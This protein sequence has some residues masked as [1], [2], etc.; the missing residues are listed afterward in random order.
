MEGEW[1]RRAPEEEAPASR[2]SS[3]DAAR[4]RRA[5]CVSK[6][7]DLKAKLQ[8]AKA[9]LAPLQSQ[10]N[11]N[12]KTEV[13]GQ[14]RALHAELVAAKIYNEGEAATSR[15]AL[16]SRNCADKNARELAVENDHL[17]AK[18][19]SLASSYATLM[20]KHASGEKKAQ[21]ERRHSAQ[22]ERQLRAS[23]TR[24]ESA[25]DT[26][27]QEALLLKEEAE[28]LVGEALEDMQ[29][30]EDRALEAKTRVREAERVAGEALTESKAAAEDAAAARY[31]LTDAG[32]VSSI[33]TAKLHRAEAKA[34]EKQATVL[35]QQAELMRGPRERTVDEWAA[36]NKESKWKAEQRERAYL[37][38]F[39]KS[40]PFRTKDIAATL[41]ELSTPHPTPP[42]PP[43]ADERQY[44]RASS[45]RV[46]GVL[47]R[48][49]QAA[50]PLQPAHRASPCPPPLPPLQPDLVEPLFK[51]EPFFT[52]YFNRVDAL[53]Q[54]L[55]K[56]EFGEVFGLF[57]HYE[58]KLT[59]NKILRLTQAASKKYDKSLDRYCTKV[60]LYNPYRKGE[61]V[62]VP[63]LAP[64]INKMDA[65]K[66]RI[67]STLSVQ[68]GEDGRL[69]FICVHKVIAQLLAQVREGGTRPRELQEGDRHAR[70][71]RARLHSQARLVHASRR[72]L[73]D[74]PRYPQGRRHL[75]LLR[76]GAGAAERRDEARRKVRRLVPPA[77]LDRRHDA[78]KRPRGQR[79]GGRHCNCRVCNDSVHLHAAQALG[80]LHATQRRRHHCS[81]REPAQGAPAGRRPH[82]AQLKIGENGGPHQG[83]QSTP[84]H[85]YQSVCEAPSSP[86]HPPSVMYCPQSGSARFSYV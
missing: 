17:L 32:Y 49:L 73:Q 76:L 31:E 12:V 37:A 27:V 28:E 44:V 62:K 60:L 68:S 14:T 42:P 45:R 13:A 10:F 47:S 72:H 5:E 43:L 4:C 39:L 50:A 67:E 69:A 20:G 26:R 9:T 34:A 59:F 51:E 21:L 55:E 66:K 70:D 18:V 82:Q 38:Q 1:L 53:I 71:L 36:L 80:C 15:L 16:R 75:A 74:A 3:R 11:A 33:L 56:S 48:V 22:R 7:K 78:P 84:G 63:R 6:V 65:S 77:V 30:A 85:M 86:D 40:H 52:V 23:L 57:L 2:W 81:A 64:P 58:M 54:D 83:L 61:V 35:E 29:E 8:T 79:G 19:A 24:T 25:A 41:D 46:L